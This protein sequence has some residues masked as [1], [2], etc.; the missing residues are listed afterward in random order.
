VCSFIKIYPIDDTK[1][2]TE[3]KEWKNMDLEGDMCQITHFALVNPP[4]ETI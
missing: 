2:F 1:Y 4:E 3:D